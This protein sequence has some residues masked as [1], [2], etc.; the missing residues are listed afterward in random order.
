MTFHSLTTRH[1]LCEELLK[2]TD[3]V[4]LPGASFERPK[5]GTPVRLPRDVVLWHA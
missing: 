1:T 5:E 4:I 3:I 2:D